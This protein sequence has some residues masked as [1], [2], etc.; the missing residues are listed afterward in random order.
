MPKVNSQVTNTLGKEKAKEK[1]D[2]MAERMERDYGD[3]VKN[4]QRV[5]EEDTLT[6]SFEAMG[7]K[8]KSLLS[9]SE[10]VV[11]VE[12]QLPLAAMPFKGMVQTRMVD[13]LQKMLS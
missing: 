1:L 10:D 9:V 8:I 5:W 3:K 6:I 12:S 7:F 13:T 4:M 2:Y 11:D